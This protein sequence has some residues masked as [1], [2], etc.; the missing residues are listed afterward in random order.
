MGTHKLCFE[1]LAMGCCEYLI[2]GMM[3]AD[4]LELFNWVSKEKAGS[5][6]LLAF[7]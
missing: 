5:V 1:S 2:E 4:V 3:V 7:G 6:M